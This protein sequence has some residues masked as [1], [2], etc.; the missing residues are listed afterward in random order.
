M[1]IEYKPEAECPKILVFF[2]EVLRPDGVD[3][4]F[5]LIGYYLQKN[6]QYE[7]AAMLYGTNG[8][9]V[10]IRIIERFLREDNCSHRSLQ[11][12]DTNRFAV[13]DVCGKLVNTFTYRE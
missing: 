11:H 8:K 9:G 3:V 12:L 1:P 4:M 13:A 10:V 6:C 5:R 7:K 2:K